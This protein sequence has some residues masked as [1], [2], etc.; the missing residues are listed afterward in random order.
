MGARCLL[1]RC[2]VSPGAEIPFRHTH[3]VLFHE[4]DVHVLLPRNSSAYM[5]RFMVS[6]A[7]MHI[8]RP[9]SIHDDAVSRRLP[10]SRERLA[11][12]LCRRY[13]L[14][15]WS[16]G[17]FSEALAQSMSNRECQYRGA[18]EVGKGI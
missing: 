15:S 13:S 3:L 4:V 12:P 2:A 17:A 8:H 9:G 14:A 18:S 1:A 7:H 6:I 10:I 16:R 11:P 5:V